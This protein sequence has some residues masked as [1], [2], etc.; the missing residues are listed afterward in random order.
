MATM[1]EFS[2]VFFSRKVLN[3]SEVFIIFQ[4]LEIESPGATLDAE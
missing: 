2:G 3:S 4:E 1:G